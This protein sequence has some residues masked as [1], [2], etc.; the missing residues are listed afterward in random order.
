MN[1][2]TQLKALITRKLSM[3]CFLLFEQM[4]LILNYS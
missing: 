3:R 2:A 4:S 1:T